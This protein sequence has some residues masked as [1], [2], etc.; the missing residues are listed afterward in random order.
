MPHGDDFV[1][2]L[3]RIAGEEGGDPYEGFG[4]IE[5]RRGCDELSSDLNLESTTS[6]ILLPVFILTIFY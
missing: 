5:A 6:G 3:L 4:N 1:P 2:L